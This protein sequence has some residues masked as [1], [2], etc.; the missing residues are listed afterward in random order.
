MTTDRVPVRS[1]QYEFH[2]VP[3]R[4]RYLEFEPHRI[5]DVYAHYPGGMDKVPVRPLYSAAGEARS[6]GDLRYT[7]RRLPRRRTIEERKYGF[8]SNYVGSDMFISIGEPAYVDDHSSV[9]ELS[10]RALCSNRHLAEH[11]PVGRGGSDFSLSDD[12]TLEVRCV[13]GPT[14][15][16]EPVASHL[17]SRTENASSGVVVW[18]L[19]NMLTLNHL[20]L[21]EHG[22][23]KNA[24]ALREILSMFAD[25]AD[26]A[27]ERRIRGIKSVE[28][29]PIVRRIRQQ[30]GIGPA[31]GVEIC[32]TIDDKAFEGSGAYLLGAILDRFFSEYAAF[33][34]FTQFALRTVER[35]EIARWPARVGARRPL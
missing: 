35:G 14:P 33:N 12:V 8:S 26:S 16:R 4:S 11:I 24:E 31:R 22:A 30:G 19:I 7:I 28:S 13:A 5:L 17:R 18:R 20:G 6:G 29:R 27:V 34:H 25:L 21:V 10:I 2:I 32:V 3:D 1:N 9:A 15:P 23:G